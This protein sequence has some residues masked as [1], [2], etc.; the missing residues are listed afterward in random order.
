M[1]GEED[2][3]FGRRS[4][5]LWVSRG[6]GGFESECASASGRLIE[7][8]GREF[9]WKDQGVVTMHQAVSRSDD[10]VCGWRFRF[11]D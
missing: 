8:G 2:E 6:G 1:L 11:A 5:Y 7:K 10:V 4:P 9:V 3:V